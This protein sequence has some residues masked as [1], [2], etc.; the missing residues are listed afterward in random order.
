VQDRV[1]AGRRA[2]LASFAERWDSILMSFNQRGSGSELPMS[3]K[4]GWTTVAIMTCVVSMGGASP[5]WAQEGPPHILVVGPIV[6]IDGR[7]FVGGLLEGLREEAKPGDMDLSQLRLDI[8]NVSSKDAAK[9]VIEP[10]IEAGVKAIVTIY[11]Q[12]TQAAAAASAASNVPI[13]FCPVADAVAAKFVS[14]NE[15]PGGNL[16][17]VA[18]GDAE[19]SRQR[20]E[21]FQQIL[22]RL[23]RLSVLFDPDFPPDKTQMRSLEQVASA[24]GITIVSRP[25]AG[26]N[27]TM[28]ALQEIGPNDADA[29][30]I[31]KEATLRH[32]S[33]ELKRVAWGQTLPILVTDPDLVVRFPA[34]MA[35]VGPRPEGLGKICGRMTSRILNGAKAADLPVE[36]PDFAL[37]LNLQ[38]VRRLG[39]TIPDVP[40]EGNFVQLPVHRKQASPAG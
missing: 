19:A 5:S 35:A 27:A 33:L 11:G 10:A 6:K 29:I 36:H 2:I 40:S 17:G 24:A 21:A 23:K 34:A 15:S 7:L 31:L 8:K 1:A 26:G 14:S 16:T 3:A 30:F 37:V 20:L 22:P 9:A 4:V 38:T 39:V 25:V 12:P 32:A 28:A 13:I 18:N